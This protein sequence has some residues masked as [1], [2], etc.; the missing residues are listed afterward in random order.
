MLVNQKPRIVEILILN[1]QIEMHLGDPQVAL[2]R[3]K[4]IS[5][6]SKRGSLQWLQAR[7]NTI[8]MLSLG[9]PD[10]AIA[11]LDQHEILYPNYGAEPYGSKLKNLHLQLKKGQNGT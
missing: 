6:G 1:A 2:S 10:E 9:S 3:W 5:S 8:S 7:F 4:T 11:V